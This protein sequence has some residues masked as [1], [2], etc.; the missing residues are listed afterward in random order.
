MTGEGR[1]QMIAELDRV[2]EFFEEVDSRLTPFTRLIMEEFNVIG[3]LEEAKENVMGQGFGQ[4]LPGL[5]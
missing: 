1:E 3:H 5:P 4:P 2:V